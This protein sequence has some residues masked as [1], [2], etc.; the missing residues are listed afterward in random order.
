MNRYRKIAASSLGAVFLLVAIGGLVRATKSGLGCG[1]NWPDCPGEVSR[2]LLIESSHRFVAGVVV[3]LLAALAVTAVRNRK[4]APQ[5][6]WPSIAAFILVLFQALLG[7]VVVWLSLRAESVVLHLATAMALFALLIYLTATSYALDRPTEASA[8]DGGLAR[9]AQ[10]VAGLVLALLLIGSY[11]TGRD[12]GYVFDDWPLMGGR[13]IPD[14]AV[15]AHAIH[16]LHRAL[17]GVTG[18]V[19]FLFAVAVIKRKDELP[20]QARLAH[21]AVGAFGVEVLVGAANVWTKLNPAVVTLH[22]ALGAAVF[23][24]LAALAVISRPALR[25]TTEQSSAKSLPALEGSR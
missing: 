10:A 22:L 6:L 17:A 14:L 18:I 20:Q 9:R 8:E 5:L 4:V 3:I 23:G 12:A 7:A 21:I 11:V 19:L 16:F 13:V 25:P 24:S 15:E 2:A 1:E